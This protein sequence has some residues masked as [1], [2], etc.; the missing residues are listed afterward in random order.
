MRLD[1]V[2]NFRNLGQPFLGDRAVLALDFLLA[3]QFFAVAEAA[4]RRAGRHRIQQAHFVLVQ[5]AFDRRE[6][7]LV[8]RVFRAGEVQRLV[9]V[10]FDERLQRNAVLRH[11]VEVTRHLHRHA[12]FY[13]AL[14]SLQRQQCR[15]FVFRVEA[16]DV[17]RRLVVEEGL[18]AVDDLAIVLGILDRIPERLLSFCRDVFASAATSHLDSGVANR[19]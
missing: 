3:D 2:G 6:I 8:T 1:V 13:V 9:R 5:Q 11:L 4:V 17:V 12:I 7:H 16:L 14:R 10:G 19:Y 18:Q 15:Q